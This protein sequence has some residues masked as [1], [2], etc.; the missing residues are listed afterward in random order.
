MGYRRWECESCAHQV[1]LPRSC[2][3]RHCP[4]CQGGARCRW[5]EQ[6]RLELLPV[7]YFHVV[8]TVPC[9]LASLAAAHPRLFYTLLF[10][11][12]RETLLEVAA[13]SRHLGAQ[14]G[15]LMVLHTGGQNLLLH[16]HVHVIVPGGGWT[17]NGDRWV[18]CPRGFFLPVKV[19]SRVFRGKLLAF[20]KSAQQAQQIT[21]TAGLSHLSNP[22]TFAAWISGLYQAAWVVSSQPPCGGPEQVLKYLARYTY[23]V[24][25]SND[26]LE[27]MTDTSI[28]F[29]YKD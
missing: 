17:P 24:A 8:F 11:A 27:Q 1:V 21:F 5:L 4:Q 7:E 20:V 28:R 2:G 3:D 25:I 6:R 16:P 26:R 19:L 14:I 18:N 15:G 13:D 23:R 9:Q 12:L 29:R 10:R 22:S